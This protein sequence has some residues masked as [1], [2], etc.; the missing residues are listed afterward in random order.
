MH[1]KEVKK[2]MALFGIA[3]LLLAV[4]IC[5][6]FWR[7]VGPTLHIRADKLLTAE[8]TPV[9]AADPTDAEDTLHRIE[10][11]WGAWMRRY[12][13]EGNYTSGEYAEE[14]RNAQIDAGILD[15]PKIAFD[16]L[17]LLA[18]I[19]RAEVGDD[20]PDWAVM[21]VGE[22]VLNRVASDDFPG[23]NVR[24]VLY[25]GGQYEPVWSAGW[26]ELRPEEGYV[27]LAWRLLSGERPS[28][29]P[30]MIWQALFPQGSETLFTYKD[31]TLGSTTYFCVK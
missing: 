29:N 19:L 23:K 4:L 28:G 21:L 2:A 22:V 24:G 12:A 8:V 16:D 11:D 14:C 30:D 13:E 26:D 5:V 1:R 25:E 6:V 15:E 7:M 10:P 27:D 20:W 31:L 18:K 9:P 3:A 17:Y